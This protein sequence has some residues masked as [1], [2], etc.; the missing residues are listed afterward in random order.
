MRG[1]PRLADGG[2]RRRVLVCPG[3][4]RTQLR[5]WRPG[6]RKTIRAVFIRAG[7]QQEKCA[8]ARRDVTE[9][10]VP[11]S[12]LETRVGSGPPMSF[13]VARF[14]HPCHHSPGMTSH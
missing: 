10:A 13:G 9:R 8:R 3:W 5:G 2:S 12:V 6:G 4:R 7:A 1:R 14:G 11:R